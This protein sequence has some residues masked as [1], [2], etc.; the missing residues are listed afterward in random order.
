MQTINFNRKNTSDTW[1]LLVRPALDLTALRPTVQNILDD[2]RLNGDSAV[3]KYTLQYD[4]IDKENFKVSDAEKQSGFLINLDLKRAVDTAFDNIYKFHG[5]QTAKK[6]IIETQPG[7]KCW[8]KSVGI[9]NVGLYIPG[10]TAPLFSTALMLGVPAMIAG[11]KNVIL[12]TPPQADGLV[13]PAVLYAAQKCGIQNIFS[14]GGVQAI[15]AMAY[16]TQSI[17]KADKI[18]G[19][20]NAYVNVAKQLIQTTGTAIDMPAGPSEVLVIADHTAT[21]SFVAA[22]LLAQAEHGADSQVVL[23]AYSEIIVKNVLAEIEIQLKKLP[24]GLFAQKALDNSVAVIVKNDDEAMQ[25]SN[26]YAPEHLIIQTNNAGALAEKVV[27]AG[28]VFIGHYS[29]ESVGDYASG[30]NHTLPTNGFARAYSGVSVDSF[31]KK[32]TFQEISAAGLKNIADT[33]TI[34]AEAELLKAHAESVRVR[35]L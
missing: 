3:R 4:K 5:A 20:G 34:M 24:R 21:P 9:E 25:V 14:V 22:D 28:S 15:G 33:V 35:L 8:R 32:I 7:I 11:C 26:F 1:Q 31:I 17:P 10:G 13:H 19:P 30:T 27:N 12:C 2:V 29:P 6:K 18:F 23:V 16:G